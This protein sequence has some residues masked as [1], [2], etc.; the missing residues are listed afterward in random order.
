MVKFNIEYAQKVF[1]TEFLGNI[2]YAIALLVPPGRSSL[3]WFL[4]I[5]L[6][7]ISGVAEYMIT[8][9]HAAYTRLAPLKKFL[10]YVKANRS[11]FLQMK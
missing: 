10:D 9:N 2:I 8:T 7:M 4:P 5:G 3:L 6:H 1:P 11:H